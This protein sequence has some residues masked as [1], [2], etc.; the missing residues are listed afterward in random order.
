MISR[1]IYKIK[2]KFFD[3]FPDPY[4]KTNKDE[5]RPCYFCFKEESTG[6]LWMIPM[7]KKIEKYKSIINKKQLQNKP[8][9]ILHVAKLGNDQESAFLIQDIF[10]ITDEYILNEYTINGVI[11]KITNDVLANIIERKAKTILMLIRK[12]VKLFN[13]Q[14]DILKIEKTLLDKLKN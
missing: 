7:S 4:L 2:D 1:G 10:P 13:T 12:G 11:L 9:D 14:P 8:C 5:S 3:D 6:L